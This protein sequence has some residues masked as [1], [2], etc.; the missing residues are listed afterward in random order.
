MSTFLSG[1][2]Q[3][4]NHTQPSEVGLYT[5]CLEGVVWWWCAVK[6]HDR[7]FILL[8]LFLPSNHSHFWRS[9]SPFWQSGYV[10]GFSMWNVSSSLPFCAGLS[11][12]SPLPSGSLLLW[13]VGKTSYSLPATFIWCHPPKPLSG[14][15]DVILPFLEKDKQLLLIFLVICL[16]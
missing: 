5:A 4:N 2:Q 1:L 9:H 3:L 7:F 14:I 13:F 16:F 10:T 8:L 11:K 6:Q 15:L 12:W